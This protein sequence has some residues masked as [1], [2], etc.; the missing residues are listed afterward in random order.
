MSDQPIQSDALG[1]ESALPAG[2]PGALAPVRTSH[3][4]GSRMVTALFMACL[5]AG[6]WQFGAG[7]YIHAK[8][9][10]AQLLIASAWTKTL[11]GQ[12][13]VKPWSWA[14]TWP[15]AR[16]HAPA[17][18]SELYVLAGSDG[19]TIAFGPGHMH[20]TPLPGHQGNSVIGG[21]RD[22]HFAFLRDLKHGDALTVQREDGELRHFRV[23]DLQVVDKFDTHVASNTGPTRITLITCWPFN[24]LQPGGRE[25]YVVSA[26]ATSAS[27]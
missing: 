10:F 13:A 4:R 12:R 21:H 7:L 18:G 24:A 5:V 19:R 16:I 20:G 3:R 25:R 15:V 1:V 2:Y 11:A 8:A 26:V 17:T 6:L 9:R 22:T 23:N 27:Y 14:D